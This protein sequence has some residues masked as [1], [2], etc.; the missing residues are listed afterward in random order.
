[1]GFRRRGG[2]RRFNFTKRENLTGCETSAAL[3]ALAGA[4]LRD[5]Q[6][7]YGTARAIIFS[8]HPLFFRAG[9]YADFE[10]ERDTFFFE[11]FMR[12]ERDRA[13]F[14][15]FTENKT[16]RM[17][18]LKQRPATTCQRGGLSNIFPRISHWR[19]RAVKYFVA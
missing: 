7:F 3:H 6:S 16:H 13:F 15:W 14:G 2:G 4:V 1:M 19:S 9:A 10:S 18:R 5:G 11:L 17:M 8:D 12:R